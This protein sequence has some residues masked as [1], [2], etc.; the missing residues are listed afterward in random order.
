[1]VRFSFG[2]GDQVYLKIYRLFNLIK[3]L[4][5]E[6]LMERESKEYGNIKNEEYD[7]VYSTPLI[8][9]SIRLRRFRQRTPP[10]YRNVSFF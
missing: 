6:N 9:K 4:L 1:M 2:V 5:L 8:R 3:K 7:V 10:L